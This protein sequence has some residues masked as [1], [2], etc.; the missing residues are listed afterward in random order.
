[1]SRRLRFVPSG[2]LVE[3]TCRTVQG[4]HLLHPSPALT[5]TTI[6]VL[7]RAARLYPVAVHGFAFLANHLHLLLTVENAQRLASFMNYLNSNLAREASLLAGWCD[8]FWARRYQAIV[9]T[10]EASAQVARLR[11]LLAN[12]TKEG[13][14]SSPLD[15]P[16]AHCARALVEGRPLRGIWRNRTREYRLRRRA[17][18]VDPSEFLEEEIL[19][20]EPLPCWCDCSPAEYRARIRR[21]IREIERTARAEN[22]A[23]GRSPLDGSALLA[24]APFRG[25]HRLDKR[26]AP[27]VHAATRAARHAFLRA[28]SLFLEAFRSAAIRLRAGALDVVFPDGS[29]PP[30]LPFRAG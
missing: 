9:V 10:A 11:Y 22:A 6:G 15:W 14:V 18:A 24:R 1:M 19:H 16:G 3:V 5:E 7:A 27:L 2:Y 26:P 25:I 13:L 23:L 21:L 12:G 8:R 17:A 20:L 28:Y 30:P 29:F 4:N